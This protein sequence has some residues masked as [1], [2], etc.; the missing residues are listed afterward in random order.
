MSEKDIAIIAIGLILH[1][2]TFTAGISVG[3]RLRKDTRH[4]GNEG[5]TIKDADWWHKPVSG[6]AEGW[7]QRCGSGSARKERTPD[8]AQRA[9]IGR[10]SLW[11]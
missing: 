11:E 2:V 5:T 10:S 7:A 1:A 8:P 9:P 4:D 6:S 3:I